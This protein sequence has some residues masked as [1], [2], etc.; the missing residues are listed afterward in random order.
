MSVLYQINQGQTA[1]IA[2]PCRITVIGDPGQQPT[3]VP[4]PMPYQ[5]EESKDKKKPDAK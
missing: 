4:V 1:T 5:Q 3:G 2:G